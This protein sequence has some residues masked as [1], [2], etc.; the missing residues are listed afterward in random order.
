MRWFPQNVQIQDQLG[1]ALRLASVAHN[2]LTGSVPLAWGTLPRR[3]EYLSAVDNGL[4]GPLPTDWNLPMLSWLDF[5]RNQL[6][7]T[8]T[9]YKFVGHTV[10]ISVS[11]YFPQATCQHLWERNHR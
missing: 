6:T 4:T 1:P 9:L 5:G 10:L 7:G 3:L 11:R 2:R 8:V